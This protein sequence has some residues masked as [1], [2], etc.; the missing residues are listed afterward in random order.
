MTGEL[1]RVWNGTTDTL[2]ANGA[3][4]NSAA[5]GQA[6]DASYNL[7]NRGDY[8]NA[9][10]VLTMT[11]AAATSIEGKAIELIIRP[12]NIDSTSDAEAPTATYRQQYY[13]SFVVANQASSTLYYLD[14]YDLPREGDVY[15]YNG[16]G[17]N[18]NSGWTL[19]M[20][21]FT[22]APT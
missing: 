18:I 2:E 1:K 15:L 17:Q 16:I 10:F 22:F 19:K 8:P 20:T 5:I 6:N 21:A 9:R 4:I 14:A 7:A 3:Q 12:L 13:G 11:P